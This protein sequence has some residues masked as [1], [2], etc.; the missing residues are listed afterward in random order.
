MNQL[1][2]NYRPDLSDH[3][4][5]FV[6]LKKFTQKC[7]A[8]DRITEANIAE[9]ENSKKLGPKHAHVRPEVGGKRL[10][11]HSTHN[12]ILKQESTS[13]PRALLTTFVRASQGV[14]KENEYDGCTNKGEYASSKNSTAKK[15]R[16]SHRPDDWTHHSEKKV[17]WQQDNA[18]LEDIK[19]PKGPESKN[20][21]ET[22]FSSLQKS[23][24]SVIRQSFGSSDKPK[25]SDT[26]AK[27]G[28][29]DT[30]EGKEKVMM[31]DSRSS[32]SNPLL[33]NTK[34]S[35]TN[36]HVP[37]ALKGPSVSNDSKKRTSSSRQSSGISS[38]ERSSKLGRR[39][40]RSSQ[41]GEASV[42]S[43]SAGRRGLDDDEYNFNFTKL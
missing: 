42:G 13:K 33:S 31:P 37:S 22:A 26:R 25:T 38:Q 8:R 36:K 1:H 16:T 7:K 6:D 12:E 4:Q 24:G 39:R 27:Y 9:W 2:F 21:T 34:L 35:S 14:D 43:K 15:S 41:S 10:K 18:K 3:E 11:E 40:K 5:A 28:S 23:K 30:N 17:R 29:K 20:H 32:I 19:K